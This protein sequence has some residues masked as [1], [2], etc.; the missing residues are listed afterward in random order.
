[1]LFYKKTEHY[2]IK[3]KFIIKMRKYLNKIKVA[4]VFWGSIVKSLSV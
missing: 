1:M 3:S 4:I 2:I